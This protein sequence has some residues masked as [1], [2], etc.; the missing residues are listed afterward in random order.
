MQAHVQPGAIR[1]SDPADVWGG[2]GPLSATAAPREA[3]SHG[4]G[5]GLPSR[6]GVRQ[7][8]CRDRRPAQA[9]G[10]PDAERDVG[11]GDASG[12]ASG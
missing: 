10:E 12:H 8:R 7:K 2:G 9:S 3:A 5:P 1:G 6:G 4:G 11:G